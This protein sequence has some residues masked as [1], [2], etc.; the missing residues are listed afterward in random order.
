MANVPLVDHALGRLAPLTSSVA[1]NVHHGRAML[2]AHLAGRVHV[3]IEA[4]QPLGTAGALG[5]LRDWVDGRPALA[6]NADAFVLD[7]NSLSLLLDDW[8]GTTVRV[9]VPGGGGFGPAAPVAGALLPWS[10]VARLTAEPSGLYAEV[11]RPALH[12]G[13]LEVI[14]LDST[15]FDCGTPAS[16]LAANLAASGGASVV[17]PGAVVEGEVTRSVVWPDAVVR[18]G[19]RLVDAIRAG[20][21]LTVLVR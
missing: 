19:E 16:Y 1:V 6:V 17:G 13:R 18:P 14:G 15:H 4:N 5:L 8:H 7:G 9:L 10:D 3:S 21:T 11:W 20:E 12:A 2:E